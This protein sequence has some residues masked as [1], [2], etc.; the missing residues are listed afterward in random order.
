MKLPAL[1]RARLGLIVVLALLVGVLSGCRFDGVNSL[2]LPGNAVSGDSYT[3]HVR[4]TDVQ[5]LLPNSIVRFDNVVVGTIRDVS[6]RQG[7]A[8]LELELGDDYP[9]PRGS[10]A[11]LAQTSVLGAQ[12]LELIPPASPSSTTKLVDGDVISLSDTDQYPA[13]ESVLAA[14]SLV[15]NGSG[16]EQLRSIMTELNSATG[17]RTAETNRAIARLK[18]FATGLNQ[19]RA[20]IGRAIDSLGGLSDRLAAQQEVI[21]TGID[22]IGPAIAVLNEQRGDLVTMLDRV[23]AFGTQAAEVLAASNDNLVASV[24]A[25]RPTLEG[26]AKS[27]DDLAGGLLVGLSFPWPASTAEK[28]LRGDYQNLFLTLDLS[29]AA[30]RDKVLGSIPELDLKVLS[31]QAV[32]PLRGP[33]APVPGGRR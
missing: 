29:V 9:I 15:L 14:L 33:L 28:G 2:P 22:R 31:R 17:G 20:D 23:G 5:N 12:Y 19:Q 3:V 6:L 18:T 7:T 32:D 10:M 25:L 21:G 24:Q 1:R 13:T 27:G 16:L 26:L 30:I 11:K 8:V 4:L